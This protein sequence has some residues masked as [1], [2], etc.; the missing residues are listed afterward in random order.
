MNNDKTT[1]Q[2]VAFAV[3]MQHGKGIIGKDP[4][5]VK[6]KF[7]LCMSTNNVVFLTQQM[8]DENR[9]LFDD[10]RLKHDLHV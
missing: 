6:E 8:D 1:E 7:D 10:Y 4:K 5:Y 2:M 3:M 9:E